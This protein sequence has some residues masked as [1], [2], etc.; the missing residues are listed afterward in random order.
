[1]TWLDRHPGEVVAPMAFTQSLAAIDL[2]LALRAEIDSLIERKSVTAEL[3]GGPVPPAIAA[4]IDAALAA[5]P[6]IAVDPVSPE[7]RRRVADRVFLDLLDELA[8]A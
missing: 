2:P 3:G 4:L 1:M 5:D 7:E 8:P 6:P